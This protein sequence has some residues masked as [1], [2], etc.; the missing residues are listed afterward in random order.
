MAVTEKEY[1][2][3]QKDSKDNLNVSAGEFYFN[4]VRPF[5]QDMLLKCKSDGE[6]IRTLEKVTNAADTFI[7]RKDYENF[8]ES[9]DVL[10][11]GITDRNYFSNGPM[12]KA[13]EEEKQMVRDLIVKISDLRLIVKCEP[14]V[15]P[16]ENKIKDSL[17]HL[18]QLHG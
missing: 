3:I 17:K 1:N 7:I 18:T 15:K 11:V 16:E 9:F 12:R 4:K 5:M 6:L 10:Q 8:M 13:S 2:Q 14:S